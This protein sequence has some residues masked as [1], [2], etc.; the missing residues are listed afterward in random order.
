MRFIGAAAI[1]GIALYGIDAYWFGGVYFEAVR[2]VAAEIK[3][4]F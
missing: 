3:Y 2:G 4:H 1:C